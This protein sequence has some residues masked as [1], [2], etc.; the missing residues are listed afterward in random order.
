MKKM[1]LEE[2]YVLEYI[3]D[4]L[5]DFMIRDMD[6]ENARYHHNTDY[7]S[8][9]SIIRTGILSMRAMCKL[10]IRR[11]S[12]EFLE[13]MDDT[14]SHI[15]GNDGI[16]LAVM[17]LTDINDD[18][19]EYDPFS[20]YKVDLLITDNVKALRNSTHY[21][22]EFITYGNIDPSMIRAVDI[23]LLKYLEM[24]EN[25]NDGKSIR[26]LM[27]RYNKLKNI[28]M[29]LKQSFLDIPFREMS[30]DNGMLLD[31]DKVSDMPILSLKR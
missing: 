22:N 9:A 11:Y 3:R 18:E 31:I 28:A 13:L 25:G 17:G 23:R 10:G 1:I 2:K 6:V 26:C 30:N 29:A 20:V 16:S 5:N 12:R 15:N 7:S 21:G 19:F 24:I 4:M 8:A 14:D 27:G